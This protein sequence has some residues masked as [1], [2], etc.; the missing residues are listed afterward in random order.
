MQKPTII[1]KP[2]YNNNKTHIL[3]IIG[4]CVS[5]TDISKSLWILSYFCTSSRIFYHIIKNI[6]LDIHVMSHETKSQIWHCERV[7]HV[8][9]TCKIYPGYYASLL[10]SVEI[11]PLSKTSSGLMI[12]SSLSLGST[13]SHTSGSMKSLLLSCLLRRPFSSCEE[14]KK[15]ISIIY[16]NV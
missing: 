14:Y 6:V 11:K 7:S 8:M 4:M 16:F 5:I 2:V 13:I 9:P 15:K 10:T 1:M 12:S 3:L